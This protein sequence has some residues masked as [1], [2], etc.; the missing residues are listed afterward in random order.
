[1]LRRV[2]SRRIGA[3]R[4]SDGAV[5]GVVIGQI[6]RVLTP[7]ERGLLFVAKLR[8]KLREIEVRRRIFRIQRQR[9]LKLLGGLEQKLVLPIRVS[10]LHFRPLEVSL[11][12]FVDDFVVLAEIETALMEFGIAVF[13][14]TAKFLDGF[15]Q[16]TV[17]LVYQAV[18]PGD[19]PA[20]RRRIAPRRALQR[21]DSIVDPTL[22]EIDA[23]QIDRA[24]GATE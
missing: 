8:I 13:Q 1:R 5:G 18:E 20:R 11:T 16:K 3:A 15:V 10:P 4:D 12:E 17:L 7:M 19:R 2:V 6:F 14:N 9:L 22:L 23:G 24:V 21:R